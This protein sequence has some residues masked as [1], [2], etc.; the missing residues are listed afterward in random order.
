MGCLKSKESSHLD[1]KTHQNIICCSPIKNNNKECNLCMSSSNYLSDCQTINNNLQNK[2]LANRY[3][4]NCN[5]FNDAMIKK[6]IKV[7]DVYQTIGPLSKNEKCT[8][9]KVKKIGEDVFNAMKVVHVDD[10]SNIKEFPSVIG[11]IINCVKCKELVDVVN[12]FQDD[13]NVYVVTEFINGENLFEYFMHKSYMTEKSVNV[14]VMQLIKAVEYLHGCG[15]FCNCISLKDIYVICENSGGLLDVK[16]IN[17]FYGNYLNKHRL[18]KCKTIQKS[19]N[20]NTS[21]FIKRDINY[22]SPPELLSGDNNN[23][24]YTKVDI[25]SIGIIMYMLISGVSPF[26][27][28]TQSDVNNA[29]INQR[30]NIDQLK[31]L[32]SE[33]RDFLCKV[34]DKDVK[35]R[36]TI[37]ECLSHKWIETYTQSNIEHVEEK[38]NNN[39]VEGTA[40]YI[41]HNLITKL[42]EIFTDDDIIYTK[43]YIIKSIEQYESDDDTIKRIKIKLLECLPSYEKETFNIKEYI[44][45][46]NQINKIKNKKETDIRKNTLIKGNDNSDSEDSFIVY[47]EEKIAN[48]F[49]KEKFLRLIDNDNS[50]ISE[51]E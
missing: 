30:V 29:I 4:T 11:K 24:D 38:R 43:T 5:S 6:H 28:D 2:N 1:N 22:Y 21:S 17:Y 15:M 14:V 49:D 50:D 34:L 16:L 41:H 19:N 8:W 37:K 44:A 33:G 46:I 27:G 42:Q 45:F 12:Y 9:F 26:D 31:H 48:K 25:W 13:N 35:R 20:N 18:D 39:F 36:L 7:G 10:V 3:S 51:I 47:S 32:S 40:H 23:I